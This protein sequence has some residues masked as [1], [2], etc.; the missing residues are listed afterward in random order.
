V[1]STFDFSLLYHSCGR[2]RTCRCIHQVVE[3]MDEN[4]RFFTEE[5]D[6]MQAFHV[7]ADASSGISQFSAAMLEALTDDYAKIPRI[8]FGFCHPYEI[9][10]QQNVRIP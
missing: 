4:I 10:A 9:L 1:A 3:A 6:N 2:S 7:F 5:C 8:T